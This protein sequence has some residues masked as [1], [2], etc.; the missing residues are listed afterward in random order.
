MCF[1][2]SKLKPRS[3]IQTKTIATVLLLAIASVGAI[4]MALTQQVDAQLSLGCMICISLI[5][6]ILLYR[7][8]PFFEACETLLE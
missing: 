5:S 6:P 1:I 3:N 7:V 2:G 8:Y 4:E